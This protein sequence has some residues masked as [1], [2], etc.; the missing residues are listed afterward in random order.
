MHD[1]SISVVVTAP[2][3]IGACYY[4]DELLAKADGQTLEIV[5]ADGSSSYVD[6]SRT[7]LRHVSAPGRRLQGLITLGIRNSTY[8]WVVVTEDHCRPLNG[9]IEGYLDAIRD[10]KDIDL[11][12]G[13]V[14]NITST[15]PWSFAVFMMGLRNYWPKATRLPSGASNANLMVRRRAILASE[16][17]LDGGLLYLTVPRL[18]R[19][20]RYKHWP[21]SMVD[22]VL[23]VSWW[24][25]M[26]HQFNCTWNAVAVIRETLSTPSNPIQIIRDCQ[27][28]VRYACLLP[29][30]VIK[31]FR[32]TSQSTFA[33][34]LRLML[35]GIL[36]GTATVAVDVTRLLRGAT[37]SI[38][39][40]KNME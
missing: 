12:S 9:F 24:Q 37:R 20:G 23:D 30:S 31:Q 34:A 27:T 10:N 3:G 25:A 2:Y 26:K 22:H 16:L 7:G 5:V 4:L 35:L 1:S 29:L 11:F 40:P 36:A 33:A 18:I 13:A 28:A 32:G 21:L 6:Q 19:S 38:A 8:E 39:N 14:E 17:E 15:S